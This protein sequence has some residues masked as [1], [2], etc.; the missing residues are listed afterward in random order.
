MTQL[1]E[2]EIINVFFT[3]I[4][5]ISLFSAAYFIGLIILDLSK[6]VTI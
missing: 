6:M 3:G 5:I 4:M 1:T 2:D